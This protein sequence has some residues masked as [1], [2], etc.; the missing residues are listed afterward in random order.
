[1]TVRHARVVR[2]PEPHKHAAEIANPCATEIAIT[3][4]AKSSVDRWRV[5][6]RVTFGSPASASKTNVHDG[7]MTNSTTVWS[8]I[9][10]DGQ[11]PSMTGTIGSPT[12]GTWTANI[13]VI[14]SPMLS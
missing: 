2:R 4:P 3:D 6:R 12:L 5:G 8:A 11:S 7:S 14:A 1:L 13:H 9:K 10:S